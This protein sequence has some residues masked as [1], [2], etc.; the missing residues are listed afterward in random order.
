[1]DDKKTMRDIGDLL[2][3]ITCL[4]LAFNVLPELALLLQ[5]L[6]RRYILKHYNKYKQ[7]Q[8]EK[9]KLKALREQ[10]RARTGEE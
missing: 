8:A 2:I 9:R 5:S 6:Y 4:N 3:T 10:L 7:R 1:M